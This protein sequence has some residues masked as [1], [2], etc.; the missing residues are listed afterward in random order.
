MAYLHSPSD[1]YQSDSDLEIGVSFFVFFFS[2]ILWICWM[3][4]EYLTDSELEIGVRLFLASYYEFL[5]WNLFETWVWNYYLS[6]SDLEIGVS[7]VLSSYEFLNETYLKLQYLS[8]SDLE[9]GVSFILASY[10]EFVEW[11]LFDT[12]FLKILVVSPPCLSI[13]SEKDHLIICPF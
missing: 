10:F 8:G 2:I 7:F 1:A 3:K 4:P 13:V 5:E 9:I 12:N 6:G 11:N